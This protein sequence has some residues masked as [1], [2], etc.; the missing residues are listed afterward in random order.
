M[1]YLQILKNGYYAALARGQHSDYTDERPL[2]GEIF[3]QDKFSGSSSAATN[4]DWQFLYAVPR[5]IEDA[6]S[7]ASTLESFLLDENAPLDTSLGAE[8]IYEKIKDKDD[9]Y[10]VIASRID[11]DI[12]RAIKDLDIHGIYI[13][14]EKLRYYPQDML[15]SHVIG[16]V[17][18]RGSER[19]G[20]YGV[21]GFYDDGYLEAGKSL[22]LSIDY[23]IQFV[24]AEKLREAASGLQAEG[25]SGIVIDPTTGEIIALVVIEEF[26]LN[27]YWQVESI[28]IFLND[29]SQKIFEP[30][31]IFKPFTMAAA[32]NEKVVSPSTKYE[33]KGKI[34][35]GKYTIRNSDGESYG[36]Q[37][38]TNVLELSLNTGAVFVERALGH[39]KF[40]EYIE[41]F[42]FGERTGVD[43][44]G[45]VGG[46]IRNILRTSR[47]INFATASFGQGIALTPI[48][49]VSAF[50]AFANGGK[51]MRPHVVKAII[52]QDGSRE[53]VEGEIVARPISSKTA[54][55]ITAMLTSVVENGWGRK[56]SVVGYKVA[57]KTGTAQVPKEDGKGYS[58]KTIHSFI[59]Y[60]P[61]YNPRFLMLLKIDN[62]QDINFSADT[63]APLFSNIAEYIL[64][65]YE[66]PPDS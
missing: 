44:Q 19:V 14:G 62:P 36:S 64:N 26:D 17:G 5:E 28:D 55:Q 60:A 30:G 54:A 23:N 18:Y 20:Q 2:R 57:G 11:E 61:A 10:E 52:N 42:G 1:F 46:D 40:R 3:F 32:I 8:E 35:I 24:L 65:Y 29:I 59:G 38:M 27:R 47:D 22:E 58:E 4:K 39:D 9:S 21:E 51:I 31:S 63:V 6:A 56:A 34:T 37:S 49:L 33:D 16:F 45:E 66:I 7:V 25:A 12:A 50:S 41:R 15:A 43:L 48:Q 53:I 13:K